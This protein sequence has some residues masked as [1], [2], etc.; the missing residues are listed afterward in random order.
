MDN[1]RTIPSLYEWAGGIEYF[2]KLTEI[3]YGK[4]LKDDLLK[5][6]FKS[7]SGEH[8]KNVAYFIA[9]VFGGPKLYSNNEKGGHARMIKHHIGKMLKEEQ[10]KRW[11]DLIL[12]SA[13]EVGFPNDP[14]FR[15]AFVAYIE[16]GSR[17]AVINS[18]S[19]QNSVSKDTPMPKWGWGETGGPFIK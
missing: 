1:I 6:I 9:E 13:D 2:E 4:V 8:I 12:Q 11:F 5:E 10:R 14:E 19:D 17:I 16:W 7:M 3:L 15:S 18:N